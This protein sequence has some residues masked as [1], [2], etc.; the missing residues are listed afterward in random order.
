MSVK[1]V[2]RGEVLSRVKRRELKLDE[3]AQLLKVSYRQAKRLLRRY[4][5]G[6]ASSLC[7]KTIWS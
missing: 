6:G 2:R 4:R 3:A 7:L 5:A 1:E